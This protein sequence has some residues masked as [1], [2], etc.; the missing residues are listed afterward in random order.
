MSLHLPSAKQPPSSSLCPG[1]DH[2]RAPATHRSR[3]LASAEDVVGTSGNK[4]GELVQ[5]IEAV[6]LLLHPD[7]VLEVVAVDGGRS[8]I[9]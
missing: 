1:P 5:P 8:P 3:S 7:V 2:A 6:L 9:I 4:C